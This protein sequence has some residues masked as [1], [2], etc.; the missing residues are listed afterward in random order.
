MLPNQNILDCQHR[1]L[2]QVR[3][4]G[5]GVVYVYFSVD[6]LVDCPEL[7]GKELCSGVLITLSTMVIGEVSFDPG[8]L[9]L[10]PKQVDLVQE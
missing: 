1:G 10:L 2:E 3:I 5:S 9:H 4:R 7:I 6:I 8:S